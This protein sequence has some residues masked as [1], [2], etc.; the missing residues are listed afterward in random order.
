MRNL[1]YELIGS[2]GRY[3][4]GKVQSPTFLVTIS[5]VAMNIAMAG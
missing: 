3:G 2:S 1:F 4:C 5:T